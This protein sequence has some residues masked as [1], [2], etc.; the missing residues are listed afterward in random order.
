MEESQHLPLVDRQHLS[1]GDTDRRSG[2]LL[3]VDRS[4]RRRFLSAGETKTVDRLIQRAAEEPGIALETLQEAAH[5]GCI[6][7]VALFDTAGGA[8][9]SD[10]LFDC[11]GCSETGPD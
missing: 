3:V 8:S 4:G 1:D 10:V 2:R 9:F 6:S 7:A 11:V 5:Q